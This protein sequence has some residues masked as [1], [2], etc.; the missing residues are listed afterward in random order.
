MLILK[1]QGWVAKLIVV[2]GQ[3]D[4]RCLCQYQLA[5]YQHQYHNQKSPWIHGV[6]HQLSHL[7]SIFEGGQ[8]SGQSCDYGVKV[9]AQQWFISWN[10]HPV[11][12][13][14][15]VHI[16]EI[17]MATDSKA[18]KTPIALQQDHS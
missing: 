7:L 15:Q 2:H 13:H 1:S 10:M 3:Q 5:L 4:H 12:S 9:L 17:E 6:L 11:L 18:Q 14:I 8:N 16:V